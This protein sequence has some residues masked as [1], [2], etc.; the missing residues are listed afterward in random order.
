MGQL[1]INLCP[2]VSF[3]GQTS[4]Q[5]FQGTQELAALQNY[6]KLSLVNQFGKK[7]PGFIKRHCTNILKHNSSFIHRT[8]MMDAEKKGCL[9][10]ITSWQITSAKKVF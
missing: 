9:N 3:K 8:S 4:L 7:N 10:S 2:A 1:F 5:A 6:S